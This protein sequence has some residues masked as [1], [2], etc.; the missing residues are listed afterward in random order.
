MIISY[1]TIFGLLVEWPLET[2][3]TLG[4]LT[5]IDLVEMPQNVAFQLGL[6]CWLRQNQTSETEMKM[7]T[8][9]TPIYTNGPS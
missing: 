4:T 6:H 7:I 5:V 1:K 3:F 2:G 8:C 9:V